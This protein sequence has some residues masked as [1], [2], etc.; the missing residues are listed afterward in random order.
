MASDIFDKDMKALRD[1][2]WDKAFFNQERRDSVQGSCQEIE[3]NSSNLKA[4]I[5]LS[6]LEVLC[7]L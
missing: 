3:E 4:T 6:S 5:V 2:R 7:G 1:K